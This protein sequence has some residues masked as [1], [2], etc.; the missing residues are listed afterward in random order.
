M[1]VVEGEGK[2]NNQVIKKGEHFILP[3]GFG[4]YS[5]DGNMMLIASCP[6]I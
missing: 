3:N 4:E 6:S 1:S 5:L 2:I